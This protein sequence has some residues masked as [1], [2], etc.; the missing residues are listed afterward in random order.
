MPSLRRFSFLPTPGSDERGLGVNVEGELRVMIGC[1]RAA[2]IRNSRAG[3]A[4]TDWLGKGAGR[5]DR[6]ES[7]RARCRFTSYPLSWSPFIS[8][9]GW[10]GRRVDDSYDAITKREI[11]SSDR[12]TLEKAKKIFCGE[13]NLSQGTAGTPPAFNKNG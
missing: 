5:P 8:G 9:E 4:D 6:N 7:N 2:E 10:E 12:P 11:K 3:A 13:N 1:W